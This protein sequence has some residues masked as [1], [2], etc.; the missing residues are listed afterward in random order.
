MNWGRAVIP[1]FTR[2]WK[3]PRLCALRSRYEFQF[4]DRQGNIR[5]VFWKVDTI[6]RTGQSVASLL[7]IT[8]RRR[9]EKELKKRVKELEEF[10]DI[11]VGREL[12]MKELKAVIEKL[13][14]ELEECRKVRV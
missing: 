2:E 14:K 11:A 13:R 9:I 1:L 8:E 12:R 6:P 5:D 3:Q 7:D 10:Y 4:T